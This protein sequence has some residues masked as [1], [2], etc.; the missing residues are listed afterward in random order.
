MNYR[1]LHIQSLC[2]KVRF[3]G[4]PRSACAIVYVRGEKIYPPLRH[5]ARTT[6]LAVRGWSSTNAHPNGRRT[7]QYTRR[8][9]RYFTMCG[10]RLLSEPPAL[11]VC[12]VASWRRRAH[13][14][15]HG[16]TGAGVS[17]RL[18]WPKPLPNHLIVGAVVGVAGGWARS[19]AGSH[20]AVHAAA[21]RNAID[22]ARPPPVL[23]FDRRDASISSWGGPGPGYEWPQLEPRN[24]RP[25]SRTMCGSLRRE[26][27]T[28]PISQAFTPPGQVPAADRHQGKGRGSNDTENLGA[29]AKH[30]VDAAS[31]ELYV[32]RGRARSRGIIDM[33]STRRRFVQPTGRIRQAGPTTA[34]YAAV[35]AAAL[36]TGGAGCPSMRTSERSTIVRSSA[37][38]I[39]RRGIFAR[40]PRVRL[41]PHERS[42]SGLSKR[43]HVCSEAF[44]AKETLASGS[45][46]DIGF[47]WIR[48]S[49][50]RS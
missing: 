31:N 19:R 25:I 4:C 24:L 29:A 6:N 39:V 21:K 40:R 32:E 13:T 12:A 37:R 44:I 8:V 20:T 18:T 46:W 11:A 15:E 9:F 28:P 45:V 47:S 36:F 48:S 38:C 41:R 26:T 27:R 35:R 5:T 17:R 16:R 22:L 1:S 42:P 2:E 50:L 30:V 3:A 33:V 7:T 34:I 49:S 10:E 14:E 43:R 23:E